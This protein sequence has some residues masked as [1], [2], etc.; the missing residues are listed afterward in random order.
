[1]VQDGPQPPHHPPLDAPPSHEMR[2]DVTQHS[3]RIRREVPDGAVVPDE[4]AQEVQDRLRADEGLPPLPRQRVTHGFGRGLESVDERVQEEENLW[5]A[6]AQENLRRARERENLRR[7][8]E[9]DNLRRAQ[10][11]ENLRRAQERQNSQEWEREREN[12]RRAQNIEV[13]RRAQAREDLRR[14]QLTETIRIAQQ[15]QNSWRAQEEETL[16]MA[17]QRQSLQ[18]GQQGEGSPR[19]QPGVQPGVQQNGAP[20]TPPRRPTTLGESFEPDLG[21]L[22]FRSHASIRQFARNFHRL[23]RPTQEFFLSNLPRSSQPPPLP[24][25][26]AVT[27][28]DEQRMASYIERSL[29]DLAGPSRSIDVGRDQGR[30]RSGIQRTLANSR[31][32]FDARVTQRPADVSRYRGGSD[33][34][35]ET[36]SDEQHYFPADAR[37]QQAPTRAR[38][39]N[40]ADR[41]RLYSEI[42]LSID[43]LY[44][45]TYANRV[46]RRP[47]PRVNQESPLASNSML[48]GQRGPVHYPYD[49]SARGIVAPPYEPPPSYESLFPQ[50]RPS[51][52]PLQRP[53]LNQQRPSVHAQASSQRSSGEDASSFYPSST[54]DSD[55]RSSS[56]FDSDYSDEDTQRFEHAVAAERSSSEEPVTANGQDERTVHAA[57]GLP[58]CRDDSSNPPG[59][60]KRD[61]EECIWPD[62]EAKA[63]TR[64]KSQKA[65]AEPYKPP[66][67]D[68]AKP[69]SDMAGRQGI[70]DMNA[71]PPPEPVHDEKIL[72]IAEMSS[73]EHF[74]SLLQQFEHSNVAKH[75]GQLYSELSTRLEEFQEQ[76]RLE[77]ISSIAFRVGGATLATGGLALYAYAVN[78]VFSKETSLLDKAAVA[79][80]I[81]PII[82]CS[83]QVANDAERGHV[84]IVHTGIC[85]TSD[86]LFLA[87]YWEIALVLKISDAIIQTIEQIDAQDELYK[88]PHFH[89]K[90]LG[91]WNRIFDDI[92]RLIGSNET[93]KRAKNR[94]SAYQIGLLLQASQLAGNVHA[95]HRLA[96]ARANATDIDHVQVDQA[97]EKMDAAIRHDIERLV[98]FET[99]RNKLRVHDMLQAEMVNATRAIAKEYDDGFFKQYW[100]AATG[101]VKF[102][103]AVPIY[104]PP[105]NVEF[106]KAGMDYQRRHDPL[107]LFENRISEAIRKVVNRLQTPAICLCRHQG[108]N[109][110]FADC[111]SPRADFGA[112]D[113]GG[114]R[115]VA[116]LVYPHEGLVS[117]ECSARFLPCFKEVRRSEKS[118]TV[119]IR[120]RQL[121]CKDGP[122]V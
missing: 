10:E 106:L 112:I 93:M 71:R 78:N 44:H 45:P 102:L 43:Q 96:L 68:V 25:G 19:V 119:D 86:I 27:A 35:I 94:F 36:P 76:P 118:A 30:M 110:E 50:G 122:R 4:I 120:S 70:Q 49:G 12:L 23:S 58:F 56:V 59:R 31:A 77:R 88:A 64:A 107:P 1:M 101:A 109:C 47:P 103:G 105:S 116:N 62:D 33:S 15:R 73:K 81:L 95:S 7:A 63:K 97:Q 98:C 115:L 80:S 22:D 108:Q 55:G 104:P 100:Q 16:Q 3:D 8:Q 67:R 111:T 53:G 38:G 113:S 39:L 21:S 14:F 17:R 42:L 84:D 79:T 75:Q 5:R 99:V 6:Q 28:E 54:S 60:S 51:T 32:P 61:V 57:S 48:E 41:G 74:D 40:L 89:K 91:G 114:R 83:V 29:V 65:E 72:A 26:G 85:F 90:R 117:P 87:G 69:S 2:D 9:R 24:P 37:V 18:R 13:L 52:P 34:D 66:V 11:R 92:E 121:W 46:G 82:G 20:R